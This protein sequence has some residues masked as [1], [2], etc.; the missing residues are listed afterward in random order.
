MAISFSFIDGC[1]SS[2]IE[3]IISAAEVD[4]PQELLDVVKFQ[5]RH[6][7]NNSGFQ[8]LAAI[9]TPNGPPFPKIIFLVARGML[10]ERMAST[11][12]RRD[13]PPSLL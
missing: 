1:I 12:N 13:P 11:G 2:P 5:T 10:M 3:G 9:E 7:A 6:V 4:R 8:L